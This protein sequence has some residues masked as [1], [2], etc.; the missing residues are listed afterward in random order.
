MSAC[1]SEEQLRQL[2]AGEFSQD[3][4]EA[5]QEHVEAC[6]ACQEALGRLS[7]DTPGLDWRYLRGTGPRPVPESDLDLVRRLQETL[8]ADTGTG[9]GPEDGPG[10]RPVEFPGPPTDKGPLGRLEF[11]HIVAE[12]GRGAFGFVFKAYDDKLD[13]PVAVKVLRP[14][15]AASVTD[16]ARFEG[17]ARKAAAVR[18]D[19]IVTIH[20]VGS[21]PG[22]ALPYFVMEYI[23]G[24]ALSQHLRRGPLGPKE[25]AE[26]TRQVALG[27]AAAHARG[28]VHRDIKSSNILLERPSPLPLSPEGRG[29]TTAPLSP[30]A[31]GVGGEG[32][33]AKITDFG[34]ART[35]EI[36][37]EKLTQSGGIVGTPPY[38]SPEQ[39]TAPERIDQ[40][41]DLYSLGVVLYEMLTGEPPFR[42]LTHLVLQQ[43][44]HEEARSLRRL[45][46]TI[47]RDLETICLCCL[48]KEPGKRYASAEA[49]AEDLR[50]FLAG[51]P[52]LA[53]PIR[54]WERGVKWARRRP[55]IAGLLAS[56][57]LVTA[58]GFTGVSW[59]WRQAETARETL[60]TNLYYTLIGLAEREQKRRIGSRAD[61][62]LDQCPLHLRGWE[63][64]FLKRLPFANFPALPHDT[65]VCRVAFSPDGLHLASGELNGN[66]TVWDAR[67]G[68]KLYTL[69]A[70]HDHQVLA[71]AFSPDGS[72]LA[73][74]GR[75]DR[76]VKVWD[77][78]KGV[79]LYTLP[80]DT[81]GTDGLAFSP[82]GKRLGAASLDRTVRLWNL[83]SGQEILTFRE[84]SQPLAADGLAFYADG[85]RLISVSVDGVV[86]VWDAAT[87]ETVSTQVASRSQTVPQ[88][89]WLWCAT[90]SSDGRWLVLGGEDGIVKVYQ[91]EPW[92]EVRVLEAHDSLV[93]YLALSSDGRRLASA[94]EDGTLKV[95]DVTTGHEAIL[96]DI[97]S[98]KTTSL[99]FSP[100][101]HRLASG[102][103]DNTVM[104]SDG[105]PG[106]PPGLTGRHAGEAITWTAHRHKVVAVDFSPDSQRLVSAG[107][108]RTVKV[109]DLDSGERGVSVPRLLL[110]VPGLP[111]GLTGVT[112][113]PDGNR[114]AAASLDGTITVCD[115]HRGEKICTL[116]GKA[117]PVYDV[118]FS[119]VGNTLA[120]AH[121][122]GTVKIWDIG[123]E[124]A[125]V[126]LSSKGQSLFPDPLSFQAHKHPVFAVAYSAD[127]RL[128]AS[129][130]GRDQEYNL[131]VWEAAT[132]NSIRKVLICVS[133]GLP[134]VMRSVAFS[135]D[136]R[137][138]ACAPGKWVS[139][140]DVETGRELFH[141]D[142]SDRS[143]RVV[144]SPD[145]RRLVAA[146]EGQTV[147][148]FDPVTGKKL[149]TLRV[150]GGQLWGVASSP[151]G[152]YLATCS[153]YKGKG[154]IQIS[155]AT[156]WNNKP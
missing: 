36:R 68:N 9:T 40:R 34:L 83:T 139:F 90:F 69:G 120:S 32:W 95:W 21:T 75:Q 143:F 18:H 104:V 5:I 74:A 25:A 81:N 17:E 38:M 45:N 59:Q 50:R 127:G 123:P 144:F 62:L 134:G 42:G 149:D 20:R 156:L 122:D 117:G 7:G 46:D 52:V 11:Y 33:R 155:N 28:L 8:A 109:W 112:F 31:R 6:R 79:L 73:S 58:L 85:Q 3:G 94:G 98:R 1:A 60:E 41:S 78:F 54:V 16:R 108:D 65:I 12:L 71:L 63:W 15:L 14:E 150:S 2:L 39:I 146:G 91:T 22:F 37:S 116:N 118:A 76:L 114:F 47:P 115:A 141:T 67:T 111:D 66:V 27:L 13:C 126:P 19:H 96:L 140:V 64:H 84:H 70:A 92:K 105:T 142:N 124:K 72:C 102:S 107:W 82:D 44:V 130:G 129:A 57:L 101:G 61:E 125:T 35:F 152:R 121:Y 80:S 138:L 10:P 87:G 48:Q 4:H 148:I 135:P 100:D 26:I 53:R 151:D 106:E 24:E 133:S 88:Q 136:G 153:G 132:G 145:G 43:V 137:C 49:L 89:W 97:H 154:T 51:E 147:R 55:A 93:L 119:P 23:E 131:G 110:S 103:A 30:E 29:E 77:V 56:I 99:A 128:L 113:S 86:K